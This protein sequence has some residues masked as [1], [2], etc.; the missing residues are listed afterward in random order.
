MIRIMIVEDH[1]LVRQGLKAL[2]EN[3]PDFEVIGEAADGQ[4]AIRLV[5]N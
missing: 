2:L 5:V 3:E 1:H 4:E